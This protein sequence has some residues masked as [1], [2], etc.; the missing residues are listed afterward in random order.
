MGLENERER[1]KERERE[2]ARK[3]S[4]PPRLSN[5]KNGMEAIRWSKKN[6]AALNPQS[7]QRLDL[8]HDS[9]GFRVQLS[10]EKRS[11]F[12]NSRDYW[13]FSGICES[14]QGRTRKRC[15][16]KT[17]KCFSYQQSSDGLPLG[18]NMVMIMLLMMIIITVGKL[19]LLSCFFMMY[20]DAPK[21]KQS[22]QNDC[23]PMAW[24]FD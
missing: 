22:N 7:E 14:I 8:K 9:L 5:Q 17:R 15:L 20:T 18:G 10:R 6:Y 16:D 24:S 11:V 23:Q 12:F 4:R 19:V 1:E 3:H 2:R 13:I 21:S